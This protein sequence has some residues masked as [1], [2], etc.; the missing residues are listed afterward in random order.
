MPDIAETLDPQR[1]RR[2]PRGDAEN[3]PGHRRVLDAEKV[4]TSGSRVV[5]NQRPRIVGKSRAGAGVLNFD[6]GRI[7][8][9]SNVA[10]WL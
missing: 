3:H 2:R 4:S 6:A 10:C 1:R 8:V 9:A 5:C 7:G